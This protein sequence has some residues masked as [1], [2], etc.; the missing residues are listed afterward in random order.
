MPAP[1]DVFIL[2]V[3]YGVE[4][5]SGVWLWDEELSQGFK[6]QLSFKRI[7]CGCGLRQMFYGSCFKNAFS[8]IHVCLLV[9]IEFS[10]RRNS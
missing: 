4:G 5:G 10:S 7:F 3:I 8:I 2:K 9:L 1:R 6:G